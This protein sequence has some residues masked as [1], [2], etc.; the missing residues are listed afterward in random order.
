M[1]GSAENEK[2]FKPVGDA[3]EEVNMEESQNQAGVK[4]TGAAD[5]MGHPV[6]EIES[7]C[8]N[9]HKN[10]ITRLLLTSIPYFKEIVIMSFE[11]PHCGFKNAEIQPASQIQEKGAKY[12]PY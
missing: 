12:M 3:A 11:C 5:S 4:N 7:L 9:C 2:L 1:S 6:Q 8:M 10:G